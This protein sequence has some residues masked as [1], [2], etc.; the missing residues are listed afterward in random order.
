[1]EILSE[2]DD[3]LVIGC[4]NGVMDFIKVDWTGSKPSALL[5]KGIAYS[6][7][8]YINQI[9]NSQFHNELIL[10]CERGVF[11]VGI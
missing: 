1:M 9:V 2:E 10:A 4:A 11:I 7:T 5:I 3:L 6:D 8:G